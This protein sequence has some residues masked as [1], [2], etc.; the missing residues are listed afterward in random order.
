[1]IDEERIDQRT[2]IKFPSIIL[3]I[4]MIMIIK[5]IKSR[6]SFFSLKDCLTRQT[7]REKEREGERRAST[8]EGKERKRNS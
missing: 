6:I 5:E 3:S 8:N 1:L 2:G 4:S 7:K